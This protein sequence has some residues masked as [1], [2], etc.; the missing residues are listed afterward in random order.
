MYFSKTSTRS[1]CDVRIFSG[2][3]MTLWLRFCWP[4]S[5]S[6]SKL[7]CNFIKIAMHPSCCT[8]K[9]HSFLHLTVKVSIF[10]WDVICLIKNFLSF[11]VG[12]SF[13]SNYS[14][15]VGSVCL[16]IEADKKIIFILSCF[17]KHFTKFIV[18]RCGRESREKNV[19]NIF[20][21]F[22]ILNQLHRLQFIPSS[23]LSKRNDAISN[24]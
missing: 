2:E 8:Y 5:K 24:H 22:E 6:V 11:A 4:N 3:D 9:T 13:L 19:L 15:E 23:F 7:Q 1:R 10:H 16:R 20:L 17:G 14:V 21:L 18:D 12:V